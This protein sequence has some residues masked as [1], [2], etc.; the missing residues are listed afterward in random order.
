MQNNF[1]QLNNDKTE[2]II[3]GSREGRLKL[4]TYLESRDLRIT[5]QAK[6]LGIIMDDEL[7]FNHIKS[8]TKSAFWHLRNIAKVRDF[9]SPHDLKKPIHAFISCRVDYCNSLFI[10]LSKKTTRQLQLIQ[11]AA[12]RILTK[13]KRREHITPVLK[14]LHWL[15]IIYRIEFK[16]LLIVLKTVNGLGPKYIS[17]MLYD[18]QPTRALRSVGAGQLVVPRVKTKQG[19]MAFSHYAAQKHNYQRKSNLLHQLPPLKKG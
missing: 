18:Y 8:I 5:S 15:S 4:S 17:R 1:L 6:N 16:V 9:I 11:N 7:C 13:T 10:G 2:I 14:S 19:E 3:F 12:S